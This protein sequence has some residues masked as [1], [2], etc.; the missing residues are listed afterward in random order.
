MTFPLA[1]ANGHEYTVYMRSTDHSEYGQYEAAN[2][3]RVVSVE[4]AFG[5]VIAGVREPML[6][7]KRGP[8]VNARAEAAIK[9]LLQGGELPRWEEQT[10]MRMVTYFRSWAHTAVR[11]SHE[12]GLTLRSESN[13]T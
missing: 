4:Q 3:V 12:A 2:D 6:T 7:D 1:Q 13:P 8:P 9:T 10:I 5:E 11:I